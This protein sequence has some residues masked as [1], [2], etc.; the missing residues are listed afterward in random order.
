M[1]RMYAIYPAR[2][3]MKI[4]QTK[5]AELGNQDIYE[6]T[7]VNDQGITVSCITYGCI[8]TKIVTPDRNGTYQNVVLGFDNLA[9]YL[10]HSP[11]FGAVVGRVAGRI[12]GAEFELDGVTYPLVQNNNGNHLHGGTVG[13]DAVMWEARVIETENEIGVEFFYMS[14]DGEEG[15][16][17]NL[18]MKVTYTLN[19]YNEFLISYN[20]VC[21]QKTLLNI[22]NHTYF[23]LSGDTERD[24]L[25]H[26]LQLKSDQYLELTD[27]LLPTGE[28]VNV[29][30]T[31]FDFREGR[32]IKDGAI[33]DHPQN[34]LA[35]RGYD[36]PFF[37]NTNHDE[38]IILW[39]KKSGRKLTI[40]TDECG[41][42]LYT[43]NHLEGNFSVRGTKS[44]NYLGL[45]L[46]TQGLPDSI[47]HPHFPSCVLDKN[48]EYRSVTK[49]IFA[50]L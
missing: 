40:E 2:I 36:H 35:G 47:H 41:V 42:V 1:R 24:I 44:R 20:G 7:L 39:D 15:Y 33:S 31:V 22:T 14:P 6:Y 8:L 23:N 17:G 30:G 28:F 29:D 25:D 18:D 43:G 3:I 9:D 5:F 16:P 10:N 12:K 19:N 46:E 34:L 38:E 27:E 49:Y 37:L 11:Y 45:C 4:T 32:T 13:F 21:D 50:T 48:E 26:K